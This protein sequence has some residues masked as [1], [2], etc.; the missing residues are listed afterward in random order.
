VAPIGTLGTSCF[1]SN[2]PAANVAP[3]GL[4]CRAANT[5]QEKV[6]RFHPTRT[7]PVAAAN[8]CSGAKPEATNLKHELLLSAVNDHFIVKRE[9]GRVWPEI[10]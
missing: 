8:D 7:I 4:R 1:A 5:A 6:G 10:R 2:P 9:T 3:G